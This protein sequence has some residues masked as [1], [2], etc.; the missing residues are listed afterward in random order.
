LP[1]DRLVLSHGRQ[2]FDELPESDGDG[3]IGRK[4]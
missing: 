3:I 2:R 4:G 1:A